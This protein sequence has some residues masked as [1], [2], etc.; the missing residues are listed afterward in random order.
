MAVEFHVALALAFVFV[1][2]RP[3]FLAPSSPAASSPGP[4]KAATASPSRRRWNRSQT[5]WRRF[6]FWRALLRHSVF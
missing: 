1:H 2:R 5:C 3:P 4:P 6:S